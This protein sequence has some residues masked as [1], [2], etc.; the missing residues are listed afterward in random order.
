M[1]DNVAGGEKAADAMIEE[2]KRRNGGSVPE[3]VIIE[4]IGAIGDSFSDDICKGFHN[5]VDAYPQL[6]MATGEAKWSAQG[7]FEV[8]ADMITR[9]G[10]QVIGVF[11]YTPDLM[12]L[13][14]VNA[15]KNAGY[16]PKDLVSAG[17]CMGP[18]GRDLIKA[19]EFYAIVNQPCLAMGE[20][21]VQYLYDTI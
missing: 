15:I 12:G 13:G 2:I 9:Y 14:V 8:T 10:D 7:A 20:L 18:E 4:I 21:A 3:G 5:V 6:T 11:A 17:V 1:N 16:D 19:G